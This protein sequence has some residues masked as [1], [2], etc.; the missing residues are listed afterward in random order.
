MQRKRRTRV[1]DPSAFISS[2][3]PRWLAILDNL[4]E[5][6]KEILLEE[7]LATSLDSS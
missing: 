2:I 3:F 4:L 1:T 5:S 6:S 7:I